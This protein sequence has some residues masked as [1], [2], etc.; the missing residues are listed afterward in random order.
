M[1]DQQVDHIQVI[2]E[3]LHEIAGCSLGYLVVERVSDDHIGAVLPQ[4][5]RPFYWV[6]QVKRLAA[7]A[8]HDCG[9]GIEG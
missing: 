1:P 5:L 9:V 7:L 6:R 4:Q 3:L 2:L 8:E